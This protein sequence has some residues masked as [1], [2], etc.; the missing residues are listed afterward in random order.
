MDL[1]RFLPRMHHSI[2]IKDMTMK[3]IPAMAPMVAM[4][5][6]ESFLE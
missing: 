3:T 6:R 4:A 1:E 2:D 5:P